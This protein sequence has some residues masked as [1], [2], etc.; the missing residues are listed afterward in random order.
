MRAARPQAKVLELAHRLD[1]DTSGL[2]VVAKTDAAHRTLADA[3]YL[4]ADWRWACDGGATLTHGWTPEA[5]F[6]PYRWEGYDEAVLLYVLGLGSPTYPLP[7]ESYAA[8][9]S[10]Y[11]WKEVYGHELIYGGPLF[12]HQYSHIWVDFRDIQDA[13]AR[14]RVSLVLGDSDRRQAA[15]IGPQKGH[16]FAVFIHHRHRQPVRVDR[17]EDVRPDLVVKPA[18]VRLQRRAAV[19]E[20][21]D[22]HARPRRHRQRPVG[23]AAA[24]RKPP[25]GRERPGRTRLLGQPPLDAVEPHARVDRRPPGNPAVLHERRPRV[26]AVLRPHRRV[27]QLRLERNAVAQL[28]HEAAVAIEVDAG[29]LADQPGP[30]TQFVRPGPPL[31]EDRHRAVHLVAVHRQVEHRRLAHEPD[32]ARCDDGEERDVH[33]RAVRRRQDRSAG[34]GHVLLALDRP[35]PGAVATR[36]GVRIDVRCRRRSAPK[37]GRRAAPA[38][39]TLRCGQFPRGTP[40]AA[41]DK[42]AIRPCSPGARAIAWTARRGRAE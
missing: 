6:L 41:W 12:V 18:G 8:W 35:A 26:D 9:A 5:G 40:S 21:V 24:P 17:G 38:P 7:T 19:A 28:Q 30:G 1:R 32:A 4:R 14:G 13:F 15:A 39:G 2:L 10:T 33:H 42:C 29:T 16:Q 22:R 25:L 34:R 23:H 37:G 31:V 20:Q 11:E 27:R 3:L 36:A